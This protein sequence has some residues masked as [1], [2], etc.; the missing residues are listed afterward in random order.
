MKSS[1]RPGCACRMDCSP[2]PDYA[3]E[4]QDRDIKFGCDCGV[5]NHG[6]YSGIKRI[7]VAA[8]GI[9]GYGAIAHLRSAIAGVIRL[10]AFAAGCKSAF[11]HSYL[12]VDALE[13]GVSAVSNSSSSSGC[14]L[15]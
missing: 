15:S 5:V 1:N 12:Q 7:Q 13:S 2:P 4:V 9:V 11:Y 14:S 10:L 8:S 3:N 6:R